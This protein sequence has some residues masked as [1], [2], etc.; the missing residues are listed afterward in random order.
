MD[1]SV[2]CYRG[3]EKV[4]LITIEPALAFGVGCLVFLF[5]GAL[6]IGIF[7]DEKEKKKLQN[8][9]I[10]SKEETHQLRS[11][12][13]EKASK[14]N[15]RF[16]T[17]MQISLSLAVANKEKEK[18]KIII[19]ESNLDVN[20][21][22]KLESGLEGPVLLLAVQNR[23]HEMMK[24]LVE[25]FGADVNKEVKQDGKQSTLLILAMSH[26]IERLFK[27]FKYILKKI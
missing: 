26:W 12:L 14:L 4:D 3:H 27:S 15:G 9:L 22:M 21:R 6:Q 24:I 17:E 2:Q 16:E 10:K 18:A 23:D 11:K 13:T 8:E 5:I 19:K 20:Q 1:P 7:T 25:D